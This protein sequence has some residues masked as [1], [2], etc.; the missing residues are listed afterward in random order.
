MDEHTGA[1]LV[2]HFY[3][4]MADIEAIA[5][6]CQEHNIPLIE[7]AAQAFDARVG[8]RRAGTFGISGVFSFGLHKT[9]NAFLGGMVITNNDTLA[10]KLR[11]AR[12]ALPLQPMAS[13]L[14]QVAYGALTDMV[15]WPPIFRVLTFWIF[16]WAILNDVAPINRLLQFDIHPRLRTRMPEA[17]LCRMRP[18]QARLVVKQLNAVAMQTQQRVAFARVYYEGLRDV[19]DLLLP[20]FREDGSHMYWYYPIQ[21][22]DRHALVK[23][24][25]RH[26]RDI[27]MSSHRNCAAVPCFAS[28]A[29]PCPEAEAAARSVI[30]LPTYPLYTAA[31]VRRTIDVIRRYFKT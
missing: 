21:Y 22:A 12:A 6:D 24:L 28:W 23:Y 1:V 5:S 27:S 9:V 18:V 20:P 2:T 29:R 19:P 13:L 26:G 16:R 15:T 17:F 4:L 14:G 8:G 10:A 3:G 7:D 11:A 31:E 25:M 30:Y